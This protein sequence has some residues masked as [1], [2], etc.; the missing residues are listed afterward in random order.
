VSRPV[1]LPVIFPSAD[2]E[3]QPGE[4]V[5][6]RDSSIVTLA[7]HGLLDADQVA[8]AWRFRRVWEEFAELEQ[9]AQRFER[10][11]HTGDGLARIERQHK[12]RREMKRCR[13]LLGQHGF[14]LVTKVCGEGW[15]IRDLCST[16]RER[17]TAADVLRIHLAS[18]AAM[19][20]Q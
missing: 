18:L 11:D 17:D 7:A 16:R 2:A 4:V 5:G 10:V 12:A 19:W 8:A 1:T 15:H 20:R 13:K 9:P 6:L 14:Q 3:E